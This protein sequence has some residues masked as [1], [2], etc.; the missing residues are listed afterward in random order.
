MAESEDAEVTMMSMD[1]YDEFTDTIE[2]DRK[3]CTC[4]IM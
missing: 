4:L 3:F 1:E 2:E